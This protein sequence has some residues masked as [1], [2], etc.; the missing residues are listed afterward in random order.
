MYIILHTLISLGIMSGAVVHVGKYFFLT[1]LMASYF[2][3][4]GIEIVFIVTS[5]MQTFGV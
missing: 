4:M 5:T 2:V 1:V 3:E